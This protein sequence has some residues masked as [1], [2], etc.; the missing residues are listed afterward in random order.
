VTS[1]KER[2]PRLAN[3]ALTIM[4]TIG[5]CKLCQQEKPLLNQSHIIPEFMHQG[6]FDQHH[7]IIK[8][9]PAEYVNDNRCILRPSSGEYESGILCERCDN[10]VIGQYETYAKLAL[11]G[12][13]LGSD[14][15]PICKKMV[16]RKGIKYT[17][18]RNVNYQKFKL[19]LLSILWRASISRREFFREVNL[20]DSEDVIRKMILDGDPKRQEDFPILFFTWL[21]DQSVPKDI[22]GQPGKICTEEGVQYMFIIGG[23]EYVFYVSPGCIPGSLLPFT[24][25]PTNEMTLFHIP[26]GKTWELMQSYFGM[27]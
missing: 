23:I 22:V 16:T 3:T 5:K 7:K 20:G 12:G 24:V 8:F 19:F 11:Y 15:G 6:L 25:L 26:E 18:C 4:Q 1:D 10:K 9:V 21:N 14:G 2:I 27:N 13:R 17:R